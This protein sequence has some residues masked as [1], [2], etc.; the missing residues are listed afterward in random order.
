MKNTAQ[1]AILVAFT[2]VVCSI[3]IGGQIAMTAHSSDQASNGASDQSSNG[4]SN[5]APLPPG[6]PPA[7]PISNPTFN[8]LLNG[9][10]TYP[11]YTVS[12]G[13]EIVVVV[14]MNESQPVSVTL[15]ARQ[16]NTSAVPSQPGITTQLSAQTFA[17]PASEI[18]LHVS[19]AS[20]VPSGTYPLAV[21]AFESGVAGQIGFQAGF[22]LVVQG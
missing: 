7:I 6:S 3:V 5:P 21:D 14:Q 18:Y 16:Q 11:P 4:N 20:N 13:E 1:L 17:T 12:P 2:L 22:N 15:S 19:V 8:L 9:S 10:A